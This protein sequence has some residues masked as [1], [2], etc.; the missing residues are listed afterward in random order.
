MAFRHEALFVADWRQHCRAIDRNERARIL[1]LAESLERRTKPEGRRN[2]QLGYIGLAILRALMFGFLN[3]RHGLCCP[4]YRALQD[5]T[6]LCRQSI[7]NGLARLELAGVLVIVRR[8]VRTRVNRT[9]PITGEPES[10]VGTV[11]TTSLY[12]LHPPGAWADHLEQPAGRRA[13]FPTKRQLSLLEALSLS[14]KPSLR[15][16]EKP[17]PTR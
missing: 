12:S 2:G 9:S 15:D 6:G 5:K 7:A 8:I 17:Q 16:R 3:H 11:Q 1:F 13:P 4:S 14:F 10:Y